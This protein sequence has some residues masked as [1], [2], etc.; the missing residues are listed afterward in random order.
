MK[1]IK[2]AVHNTSR[3]EK[4]NFSHKWLEI[5]KKRKVNYSVVDM[6]D[7][8]IIDKIRDCSG[9]MWH[10]SHMP[11]E[12]NSAN[13]ILD[14]IEFS[15]KIKIFPNH[16]T[17]W[18]YDEKISQYY[19]LKS[20][21]V[22][23]VPTHVFWNYSAALKYIENAHYPLIF[24]L[25]VGAGSSN[26][27]KVCSFHEARKLCK[28]MFEKG[29]TPYSMNEF[30]V[31]RFLSKFLGPLRGYF[32]LRYPV[33]DYFLLQKNYI[34]L[35]EYLPNDYDIRITV[36]GNRAFGFTRLNRKNDFRASGSG[37]IVYNLKKIPLKA[38]EISFSISN[39]QNFQSMAYDF[40][41][42]KNGRPV[43]GEISYCF[44]NLAVY[45]CPGYWDEKLAWHVGH[46]WPEELII[47]DFIDNI[48]NE[49]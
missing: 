14:G 37:N 2:I 38:V 48:K 30:S 5:L 21:D 43:V 19:L 23:I 33:L 29:L 27:V 1:K 17:R 18:H 25:S 6:E 24:K 28:S 11:R 40:L 8:D 47:S 12:K 13:K 45:N 49:K 36:I 26:V 46:F 22:P 9:I 42:D 20:M 41:L 15:S 10:W 35:Q 44:N 7:E 16:S 31:K 32:V 39:K 34:Y 3:D 4:S